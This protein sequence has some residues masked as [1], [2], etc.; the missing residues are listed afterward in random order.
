LQERSK[1]LAA[2]AEKQAATAQDLARLQTYQ[3]DGKTGRLTPTYGQSMSDK[4][5][6]NRPPDI[7]DFELIERSGRKITN[8]D[9]L[10]E[11]WAVCFIFTTCPG[12]CLTTTANMAKLQEQ[13][14]GAP[15]R[16]VTISVRPEYDTP[17]VLR[18]YADNF[19]A[20]PDRWLFLT[21][22][23]DY[24][25]NLLRSDFKQLVQEM[26]GPDVQKGWEVLH[27]DD[28]LHIDAKG[29]IVKRYHGMDNESMS[30]LR[31]ALLAEAEQ[32]AKNPAPPESDKPAL[33]EKPHQRSEGE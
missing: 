12:Q 11:P 28:V 30:S 8:K 24:V 1:A 3:V 10:G 9:L 7:G 19:G 15:V 17:E 20:D 22:E 27:T 32:I 18:N 23:K 6:P 29:R 33:A 13:L 25:Y 21:G 2:E 14:G 5:D 16:L 4:S 26:T 31:D